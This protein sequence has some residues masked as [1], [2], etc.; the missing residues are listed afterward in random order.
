[1]HRR[2]ETTPKGR[3]RA[4]GTIALQD[5]VTVSGAAR[6]LG[7]SRRT[8]ERLVSR[9]QLPFYNLPIRGGLRFERRQLLDWLEQRHQ[10]L[11]E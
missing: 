4:P 9:G 1:M 8:I 6:L 3:P 2:R 5:L 11:L 7:V 10:P